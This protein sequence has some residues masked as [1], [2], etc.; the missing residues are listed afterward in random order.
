MFLLFVFLYLQG[1]CAVADTTTTPLTHSVTH[2]LAL[3]EHDRLVSEGEECYRSSRIQ[4]AYDY[5]S[6]SECV[7][8]CVCVCV[9]VR[10]R[11]RD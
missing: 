4:C 1:L 2:S 11:E 5:Y 8:A 10:E 6:V 3:L 9:C 7:C